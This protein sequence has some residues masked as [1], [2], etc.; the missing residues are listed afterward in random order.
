MFEARLVQ[1]SLLKTALETVSVK[2][3]L[4][5]AT[6]DCTNEGI[7]I[8][9]MDSS[10][11]L[12]MTLNIRADGFDEFQCDRTISMG[13]NLTKMSKIL[14][15]GA[16]EDILTMKVD[17]PAET[18]TF[19]FESPNLRKVSEYE[20]KLT[21]LDEEHLGFPVMAWSAVIKMPSDEFQRIV[22]DL[23]QFGKLLVINCTQ[24]G[25]KFSSTGNN[26]TGNIRLAQWVDG[27]EEE[28]VIIEMQEEAVTAVFAFQYLNMFTRASRLA[29]QVSLYIFRDNPM[30]VEYNIG[31]IGHVRFY[32]APAIMD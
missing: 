6:L 20:M 13:V 28:A 5:K 25:V 30:S 3:L 24:E 7:Q 27:G 32:L 12:L 19:T 9:A 17:D 2:D 10:H 26:G 4:N 31:E 18:V 14:R 23:S 16:I 15:Y 21:Q 29:S 8:Q 22:R 1:G 11:V